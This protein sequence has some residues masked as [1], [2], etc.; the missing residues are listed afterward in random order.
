MNEMNDKKILVLGATGYIGA[1]LIPELLRK[2]FLVG[3][4][5]RSENKL[6]MRPWS[7]H[8]GVEPKKVDVLDSESLKNAM[9]DCF[10]AY[11]LVHSMEGKVKDFAEVDRLAAQ[12]VAH[13]A[14]EAGLERVIYLGGLGDV[15]GKLS[16]HLRSRIEVDQI[17]RSGSVPVTTLRAAI[18]IGS[19]SAAFEINRYLVDRLPI[20]VT[21]KWLRTRNQPIAIRNTLKYLIECLEVPES[22]GEIFDIGGPEIIT[23]KQLMLSYAEIAGLPKPII[24]P[25]PV[26]S[27][28]LSSYWIRL[29]TGIQSSLARPLAKGMKNEVICRDHR[30]RTLIPQRLL[31]HREAIQMALDLRQYSWIGSRNNMR[32]IPPEWIFPGDPHW[33]G[34]LVYQDHRYVVLEAQ[35]GDLW[36]VIITIGGKQGYYYANWLWQFWRNLAPLFDRSDSAIKEKRNAY[37]SQD[38]FVDFWQIKKVA[39]NEEL[40]LAG[41]IGFFGYGIL[42]FRLRQL[43]K[44]KTELHQIARFVPKGLGGISYWLALL[45]IHQLVFK[46]MLRG[47]A[48][49]ANKRVISGPK[50]LFSP[51]KYCYSPG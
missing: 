46:G 2:G 23:Y 7:S 43:G 38:D 21:P 13:C 10:A 3:A 15:E 28:G 5:Y 48:K 12:N 9:D 41:K 50:K 32:V 1:R 31:D 34:G 36:K 20:M 51:S 37:L 4:G 30:I 8:K 35:P 45:P 16:K 25:V 11:Y 47:I 40:L 19:G 27:P 29:I 24:I 22:V 39:E 26:F 14:E 42:R 44:Y 18:I 6:A 49:N 17:L 33:A